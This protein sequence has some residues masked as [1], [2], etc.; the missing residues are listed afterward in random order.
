MRY[1]RQ[2]ASE[3][4][5][6]AEDPKRTYKS[7]ARRG[8]EPM[9]G[10]MNKRAGKWGCREKTLVEQDWTERWQRA[11]ISQEDRLLWLRI[12]LGGGG[13]FGTDTTPTKKVL[14]LH[15]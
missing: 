1:G 7:Y 15:N 2:Q 6:G 3:T 12:G 4:I 9:N 14:L 5:I 11:G 13:L 10:E 8:L